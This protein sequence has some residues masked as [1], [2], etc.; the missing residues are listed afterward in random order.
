LLSNAQKMVQVYFEED[1]LSK[2]VVRK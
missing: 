2:L 1:N